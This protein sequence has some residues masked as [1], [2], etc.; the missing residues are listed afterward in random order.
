[1][2][3]G[4]RPPNYSFSARLH[5]TLLFFAHSVRHPLRLGVPL[6]SCGRAADT[7]SRELA[8][9]PTVRVIELGAGTGRLTRGILRALDP[10][11][12]LLCVERQGAFCRLLGRRFDGRVQVVHADA[13]ELNSI[14]RGSA[15]EEPDV[16]VCSVP[17]L[18]RGASRL[19]EQISEA[20]PNDGSYLQLTNWPAAMKP[21][22]HIERTYFFPTNV[23]PERLYCAVP[24]NAQ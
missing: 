14:I 16:I 13:W 10:N 2:A 21:F 9:R 17:L 18:G 15:W 19:C 11:N 5:D 24:K 22:F 20:L 4:K 6:P 7:V 23:P 12:V 8:S 1:M 3:E